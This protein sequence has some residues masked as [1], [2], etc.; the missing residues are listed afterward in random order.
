M[1]ADLTWLGIGWELPVW[2]QSERIGTYRAAMERLMR[3]G[4][5]YPCSCSRRE[6]AGMVGAP[7]EEGEDEPVYSGRCRAVSPVFEEGLRDGVNYRFRVPDGEVVEFADGGFGAQAFRCGCEASADFGDFLVWR[8]DGLPS[9]QLACVVDDAEMGITE[10]VRGRDL[11]RSTARQM[12]LQQALGFPMPAYFHTELLRNAA[13]VRLA[14]R[15]DALAIR[16]L[17]EDGW[18]PEKIWAAARG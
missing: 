14:K 15:H 12:L 17:R 13:G 11:L 16:R 5:V 10:V 3:A 1:V 8:K 6:L 2:V 9:Y 18:T 4:L 7:H